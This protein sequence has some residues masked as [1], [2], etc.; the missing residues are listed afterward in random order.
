MRHWRTSSR[1]VIKS[2]RAG[3][4][5]PAT[6]AT[7]E[8]S[9]R[10]PRCEASFY[11]AFL[12]GL[13]LYTLVTEQLVPERGILWQ[14]SS[15]SER[16]RPAAP[17]WS[18]PRAMQTV[19]SWSVSRSRPRP[20]RRLSRSSTHGLPTRASPRWASAPLA[21]PQS[22]LPR[23]NTARSWRRPKRHGA[24]ST[25]W[26]LSKTSSISPAATIPTSTS[27]AWARSRLV[28]PRALPMWST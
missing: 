1:Y 7:K 19:R 2:S 16:S 3:K 27:P 14:N 28:V 26:A 18:A 5:G 12:N 4:D 13:E 9:H 6:K 15:L 11:S 17:R 24:T 25:C 20:R 23:P 8:A 21:P 22:T 10:P